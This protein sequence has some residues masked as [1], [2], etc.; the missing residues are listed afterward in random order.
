MGSSRG[1]GRTFYCKMDGEYD[2]IVLGTGLKE[3]ILSG[4][5]S[6]EGKKV[7]HLDRN[8]YY[9]GESASLNLKQLFE[10]YNKTVSDSLGS[11]RDYNIDLIPKFIMANGILV[12]M[13]IKTD[14]T[15]YLEFKSVDGSYVYK[16]GKIHK[17]PATEKE[18]LN[19]PLMG[20]LEKN[21]FRKLL[22]F[23]AEVD[24][25]NP[26]TFKGM[27]LEKDPMKV[28]YKKFGLDDSTIE[29]TG[30]ALAL[31][32]ND[33]YINE[34]A[35]PTIQKIRLYFESLARYE[36]SPYIYPLY[37]LGDLPQAFARL[38]AIYEGTYMLETKIDEI[39][40]EGG[41]FAGVK[42]GSEV[43]KAKFVVGDP[44]YFQKDCKKTGSVVLCICIL[45][46]PVKNTNNGEST[47]IVIPQ[48]QVGRKW[49]IYVTMVSNAH[50]VAPKG[51]YVAM[52]STTVE[53]SNPEKECEP[54]LALLSPILEKVFIVS[55]TY[56]PNH[57]GSANQC[58]ISESYDA[59]SHFETTCQDVMAIYKR[60]TG[61]D[62]D[63]TPP[64]KSGDE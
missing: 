39:L 25:K 51:K 15:K 64:E 58:F 10:K 31:Q 61:K 55:D 20:L 18:A 9:G 4:L 44:S 38:S 17:V 33:D 60:I 7:L 34:P 43:A 28:V 63:L 23:C 14:V 3:C 52:V 27:N 54:G 45:D 35:M 29:F 41:K 2:C 56:A 5:L 36:K 26:K 37:G 19:S 6:C 62:L 21:R 53:T 8:D 49:D 42:S 16:K 47:Q 22:Q 40:M 50:M 1:S 11:S 59:T 32:L 48:G 46:H 12:S 57:D 24:E 13:L 30:H